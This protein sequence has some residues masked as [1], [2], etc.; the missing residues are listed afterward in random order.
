MELLWG[1]GSLHSLAES[2]SPKLASTAFDKS[3]PLERAPSAGSSGSEHQAEMSILGCVASGTE[4]SFHWDTL[5]EVSPC[6][7]PTVRPGLTSYWARAGA[8]VQLT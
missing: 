1:S 3:L 2:L 8:Q 6:F 7:C 4:G 5:L